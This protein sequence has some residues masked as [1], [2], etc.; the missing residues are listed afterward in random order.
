MK[1]R[2]LRRHTTIWPDFHARKDVAALKGPLLLDFPCFLDRISTPEKD[3]AALKALIGLSAYVESQVPQRRSGGLAAGVAAD[4]AAALFPAA[5]AFDLV[6]G[7]AVL[8]HAPCHADPAAV[9]AEE[10]PI[11]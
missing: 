5:L 6:G 2:L 4:H 11:L 8:G 10:L 9:S 1:G 7:G 3:V